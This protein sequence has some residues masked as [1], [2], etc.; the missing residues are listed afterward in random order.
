[1]ATLTLENV[2]KVWWAVGPHWFSE[3]HTERRTL[4]G[5]V[6]AQEREIAIEVSSSGCELYDIDVRLRNFLGMPHLP[7]GYAVLSVMLVDIIFTCSEGDPDIA[8]EWSLLNGFAPWMAGILMCGESTNL[9]VQAMQIIMT[10]THE[11]GFDNSTHPPYTSSAD[12]SNMLSV[13]NMAWGPLEHVRAR[14]A[15]A[16]AA[17]RCVPA[18][19]RVDKNTH[20][21]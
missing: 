5:Y 3:R 19:G 13:Q 9:H 1:M 8:A 6:I 11:P 18:G 15:A 20:L 7:N 14:L 2:F 4:M 10:L 21:R 12:F 16:R 17:G